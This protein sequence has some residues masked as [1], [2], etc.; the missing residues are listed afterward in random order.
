MERKSELVPEPVQ[1]TYEDLRQMPEDGRR[2]ELMEGDIEVTPAPLIGHQR[3][4]SNLQMILTGHVEEGGLGVLLAAPV[5]VILDRGTVVE[6]DLVYVARDHLAILTERAIEGPPDLVVEI[7]SPSTEE[8]DRG[9][10]RRIY[11]RHGIPHYWLVDPVASTLSELVLEQRAYAL[12][13]TYRAGSARTLCFPSLEISLERVFRPV[14]AA[15]GA[16]R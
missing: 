4:S 9:V 11:A 7:L 8:R 14:G 16:E 5:D 1:L 13:G 2:Y 12:R 6:P 10:K 3:I 15:P